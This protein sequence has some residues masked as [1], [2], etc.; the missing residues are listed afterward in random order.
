V[1]GAI[2]GAVVGGLGSAG[3]ILNAT[4]SDCRTQLAPCPKKNYMLLHTVTITAG[5]LAGGFIGAKVG[6]WIGRR[7]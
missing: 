3:Y 2:S 1:I 4:A 5:T 7:L 6:N